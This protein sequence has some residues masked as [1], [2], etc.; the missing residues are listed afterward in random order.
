MFRFPQEQSSGSYNQSIAK[1]TSLV[2]LCVS[3]ETLS[4]LWRHILT[5]CACVWFTVPSEPLIS[6]MT[7]SLQYSYYQRVTETSKLNLISARVVSVVALVV[8][9][10]CVFLEALYNSSILFR[11]FMHSR[12]LF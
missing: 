1:F 6:S 2:Q 3:V 11:N 9:M 4:M 5:W 8:V 7:Q 12:Y 10:Q